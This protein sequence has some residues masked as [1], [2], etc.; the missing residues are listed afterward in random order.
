MPEIVYRP[1]F[2]LPVEEEESFEFEYELPEP[3]PPKPLDQLSRM[4][5]N[6]FESDMAMYNEERKAAESMARRDWF[7]KQRAKQQ[8]QMEIAD[9]E[10]EERQ[11][12]HEEE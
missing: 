5:K 2:E 11:L 9:R 3:Q 8:K 4:E 6:L 12:M 7:K 1:P 10:E